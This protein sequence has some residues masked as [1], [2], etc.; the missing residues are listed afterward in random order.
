MSLP[1][2]DTIDQARSSGKIGSDSTSGRLSGDEGAEN[3][4]AW[5]REAWWAIDLFR[6][7]AVVTH[8]EGEEDG[9]GPE[10]GP[11]S[12]ESSDSLLVSDIDDSQVCCP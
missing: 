12:D 11:D 8:G 5:R 3:G 7:R 9:S 6:F 4:T 10:S 1:N 2:D